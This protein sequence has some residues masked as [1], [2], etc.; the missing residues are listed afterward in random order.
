MS[1]SKRSKSNIPSTI[2]PGFVDA[3]TALL[4]MLFFLMSIFMIV[5]FMLRDTINSQ[6][7]ELDSLSQ[8]VASLAEALGLE[9]QKSFGLE[10][11]IADLD[12]DLNVTNSKNKTQATL[13][14]TLTQ[15]TNEQSQNIDDFEAQ[16]A[17][18]L[19]EKNELATRLEATISENVVEVSKK[20]ALQVALAQAREEID[21]ESEKARLMAAEA[22]ALELLVAEKKQ[23]IL[24]MDLSLQDALGI[25]SV[26]RTEVSN[27]NISIDK[28]NIELSNLDKEKML[29]IAAKEE[30]SRALKQTQN[31]L[32][33]EEKQRLTQLAIAKKLREKLENSSAELTAMSL[34][35]EEQRKSL[36]D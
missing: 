17:A 33:F 7:S 18:L 14:A 10:N 24:E 3:M 6:D 21:L 31:N 30:L 19:S 22:D 12:N 4:L 25:L 15:Q 23:E 13:I 16:V 28:L 34:V 9:Q 27:L 26:T 35:L 1:L 36:L 2:W 29:E 5:Q 20:E 11:R 32:T 8:Q